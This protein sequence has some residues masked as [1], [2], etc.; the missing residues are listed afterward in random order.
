ME[1]NCEHWPKVWTIRENDMMFDM[2]TPPIESFQAMFRSKTLSMTFILKI[3][4]LVFVAA[5]GISVSQTRL[6]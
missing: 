6:L 1:P 4:I 3:V 2:Y 5:G